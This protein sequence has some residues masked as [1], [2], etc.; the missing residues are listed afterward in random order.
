LVPRE[1]RRHSFAT[2]LL[3]ATILD[4]KL[5]IVAYPELD[6]ADRQWIETIRHIHDPQAARIGVHITLV[7]PLDGSASDLESET[8]AVA[9]ARQPIRFVIH[10]AAAVPD[11][12][13]RL[14]HV[15]LVPDEGSAQ[16][17]ELHDNLYAGRL[18]P[19]LRSDIAYIPHMTV[20]AAVDW[21]AAERLASEFGDRARTIHGRITN[22]HVVDVGG[23]RVRTF[24]SHRLGDVAGTAG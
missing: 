12:F 4:M 8:E 11:T 17:A 1:R 22:L 10:H 15:F 24:T 5:A 16:I 20:G 7:F 23:A 19:H 21:A 6:E 2:H 18:R 14:V 13:S 9:R 3:A